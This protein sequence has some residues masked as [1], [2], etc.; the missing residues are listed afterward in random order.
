MQ[1]GMGAG[2]QPA[3]RPAHKQH[4]NQRLPA[5]LRGLRAAL[6]LPAGGLRLLAALLRPR[7]FR[8]AVPAGLPALGE[9]PRRVPERQAA[10][11]AARGRRVGAGFSDAGAHWAADSARGG[12]AEL[13]GWGERGAGGELGGAGALP[14]GRVHVRGRGGAEDAGDDREEGRRDPATAARAEAPAAVRGLGPALID[15]L[16]DSLIE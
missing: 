15:S 4:G 3:P 5:L 1:P 9:A 16:I 14:A 11:P 7:V 10:A 2:S 6:P 13:P 8:D 12:A